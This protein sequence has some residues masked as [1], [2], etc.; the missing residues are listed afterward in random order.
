MEKPLVDGTRV[1]QQ[2]SKSLLVAADEEVEGASLRM[3]QD[4]VKYLRN[5]DKDSAYYDPK[6]RSM[7]DTSGFEKASDETQQEAARLRR[8]FAWEGGVSEV[9]NP[10]AAASVVK[11]EQ[12]EFMRKRAELQSRYGSANDETSHS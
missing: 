10:T 2:G 11:A 9:A 8:R 5:M 7:R 3:R 12:A 6:S 1:G 4:T